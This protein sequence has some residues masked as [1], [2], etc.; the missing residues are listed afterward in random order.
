MSTHANRARATAQ[1]GAVWRIASTPLPTPKEV[2]AHRD[3][4][5]EVVQGLPCEV[6]PTV[7]PLAYLRTK[8]EKMGHTLTRLAECRT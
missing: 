4:G 8:K 3:N 2:R 7:H 1:T 5:I 6:G